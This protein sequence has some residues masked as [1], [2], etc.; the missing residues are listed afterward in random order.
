M[1]VPDNTESQPGSPSASPGAGT[2][3][4]GAELPRR[5]LLATEAASTAASQAAKALEDLKASNE[6]GDRSCYKLLQRPSAFYPATREQEI[7][8][9]KEWA[10]AFEPYL[11]NV[12]PLFKE[13]VK[14]LRADPTNFVHVSVQNDNE[15]NRGAL[16]YSLVASLVKQRPLMV[17]RSVINNGLEAYRHLLLSNEPV[18]KNRA[19]SLLHVMMNWPQF[20][21]TVSFLSQ[22]LR[23][24]N[25][26]FECDKLG[27]KLA[28]ELHTAA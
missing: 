4:D 14:V 23:L 5:M 11:S 21:G 3:I 25:A 13:D 26:V 16:L 28:E 19:L 7:S 2:A 1:F 17:V 12:D 15:K 24:E 18:K 9:W 22:I 27:T 6:K 10:W 8:L 20:N